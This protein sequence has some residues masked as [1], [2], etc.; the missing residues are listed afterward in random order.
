MD[1][2]VSSVLLYILVALSIL[3]Y[4]FLS[5]SSNPTIV[6]FTIVSIAAS[7]MFIPLA[8]FIK[9]H[10]FSSKQVFILLGTGLLIRILLFNVS[11]IASDD[12]YRYIWDG[13]VF[14][15]GINP[16]SF[17]ADDPVLKEFHTDILPSKINYADYKTIYP[18]AAQIFFLSAYWIG[19]DSF[20]GI[21]LL[22]LLSEIVTVMFI[23][24]TL[25]SIQKPVSYSLVYFLCP[26]PILQFTVDAH[27]DSLGIMFLS[28]FIYFYIRNK[29]NLSFVFLGFSIISKLISGMFIPVLFFK[30]KGKNR[31]LSVLIPLLILAFSYLLFSLG[32]SYPFDALIKFAEHWMYN[33]SVFKVLHSVTGRHEAARIICAAFF[34]GIW[35]FISLKNGGF[36]EKSYYLVLSFF[37]LASTVHPWYLN[38]ILLFLPF[39]F[40]WSGVLWVA[41]ASLVNIDLIVYIETGIWKQSQFILF[42][43]YIPVFVFLVIELYVMFSRRLGCDLDH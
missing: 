37:L 17:N 15:A 11:P 34:V 16:Y 42:A 24:L 22:L 43:E 41:L 4:S 30:E 27:I 39:C 20:F 3:F 6:D 29:K 9:K 2:K 12:I 33:G 13:K 38:W 14:S 25:K 35:L 10:N 40:R 7:I 23:Y 31:I 19:G 26:L 21:K 36:F 5:F 28:G 8:Y 18:P 1:D 32:K